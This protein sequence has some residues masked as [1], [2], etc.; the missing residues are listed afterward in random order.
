MTED[1]V[2]A[3]IADMGRVVSA[4]TVRKAVL[5]AG[6]V[7]SHA[8][9]R[10]AIAHNPV[11]RLERGERPTV[12]RREMRTLDHEIASLLAASRPLYRPLLATAVFTGLR[13]GELLGLTWHD[14][15][16]ET[17]FVRV[18]KQLGRD[19]QRVKPKTPQAVREV[20]LMPLS[21]PSSASTG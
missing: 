5:V 14:V 20:V 11:R 7:L 13:L 2:L 19:G 9:R 21:R 18:R 15:D 16:F 4:A 3:L 12:E 8:V 17:G 6:A 10:G 1:D